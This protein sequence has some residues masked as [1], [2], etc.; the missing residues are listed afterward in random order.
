M[1]VTDFAD[2]MNVSLFLFHF[3]DATARKGFYRYRR[4]LTIM[5][6]WIDIA[7]IMYVYRYARSGYYWVT[8]RRQLRMG[9]IWCRCGAEIFC[10]KWITYYLFYDEWKDARDER[11]HFS[12]FYH[13]TPRRFA[14]HFR[15][16]AFWWPALI[17]AFNRASLFRFCV[18]T[19]LT[20]RSRLLRHR[21]LF[22]FAWSRQNKTYDT[23]Y[24]FI[25]CGNGAA[26]MP[27]GDIDGDD[28]HYSR[29]SVVTI[30]MAAW[31]A[32]SPSSRRHAQGGFR[33][34]RGEG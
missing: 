7:C 31:C 8:F 21:A 10:S 16:S 27:H 15:R 30:N 34:V 4:F 18:Q 2:V 32:F 11:L 19:L 12:S 1:P 24:R 25:E 26:P 28:A 20:R 33:S 3:D 9:A 22:S 29:A 14:A 23:Y 6:Y 13:F 5:S 17:I